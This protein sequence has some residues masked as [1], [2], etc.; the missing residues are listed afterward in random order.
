MKAMTIDRPNYRA[1]QALTSEVE[2]LST[3]WLDSVPSLAW[4][5]LALAAAIIFGYLITI[6][7][8]LSGQIPY[9]TATCI[10]GILCFASFTVMHEAG[11]GSIVKIGSRLKPMESLLGWMFSV[12]LLLT[13]YRMFQKIH[14]RHH[15]F[16]NDPDRDPDHFIFGEKWYQV[17]LSMVFM[18]F[19]YHL[20]ILTRYRHMAIFRATFSSTALY[21]AF[22]FASLYALSKVGYGTEIIYFVLLPTVIAVFLLVMLFDYVPHHPHKSQDPFQNTRI[23]P[24]RLLNIVLLGQNYHLIHHLY[25]RVPWYKYKEVFARTKPYLEE[26]GA[27][28]EIFGSDTAGFM[29][30]P[31]AHRLKD[32]GA[33]VNM[34]LPVTS[35]DRL[36][37]DAVAIDFGVPIGDH[38]CFK[39]GQYVMISR[40]LA[41]AQ[42]TRCY[43]ICSS[44]DENGLTIGVRRTKD[45]LMS[46]Y[47]NETL[48]IGDELI[49]QG[50]F[51]D[52]TYPACHRYPV[53]CLVLIAGG[54]GITPILSILKTALK[55]PVK[56]P[57]QLIYA[58]RDWSSLMFK[59]KINALADRYPDL[60]TVHYLI[61]SDMKKKSPAFSR[62]RVE[63]LLGIKTKT[64]RRVEDCDYYICGPEG[65]KQTA[66]E[67]LYDWGV[68]PQRTHYEDF[69]TTSM[70]PEG[71]QHQVSIKL[72]DGS[73][74]TIRVASNQ[75]V[76]DVAIENGVALPHACR[77]GSCGTCKVKVTAGSI[78]VPAKTVAGITPDEWG[79][80]FTLACQCKPLGD[81]TLK[82]LRS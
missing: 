68:A 6:T 36:T 29:K 57:I 76:L 62:S 74:H 54:S 13:P 78:G 40:W 31:R 63:S 8:T 14:D 51:G 46:R 53:K 48:K 81:I 20:L 43:S 11:H 49:V 61:D 18:P 52:F 28:I 27:P 12:P 21:F 59:S 30:S 72:A 77:N 16:T 71:P 56:I 44:P 50:P 24:S 25:P 35:L 67:T 65:L 32:N 19:Q 60:L 22:I 42:T 38:M 64:T 69:A 39:A 4:G 1:N 58:G 2:N 26:R 41:G 66:L 9:W 37:I 80:G 70:A 10:C 34:L 79:Q 47:L 3:A 17:A 33:G 55:G 73:A 23:Y 45:G 75:T 7:G 5:T 15:A 82:E